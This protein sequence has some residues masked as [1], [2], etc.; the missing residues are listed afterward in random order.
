MEDHQNADDIFRH[1]QRHDNGA[2]V[3]RGGSAGSHPAWIVDQVIDEGGF[4]PFH[5]PA[6]QPFTD[7]ESKA[8][9]LT[10]NFIR[11]VTITGPKVEEVI[12]RVEQH[13]R[14]LLSTDRIV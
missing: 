13:D 8:A 10:G 9:P 7:L 4:A 11:E 1:E 14:S 3:V 12:L 6:G 5:H 2:S